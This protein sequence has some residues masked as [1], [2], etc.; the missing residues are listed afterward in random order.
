MAC[1]CRA[2]RITCDP[3]ILHPNFP[4]KQKRVRH[5]NLTLL[6]HLIGIEPMTSPL[7]GER[8]IL[9]SYRCIEKL[10]NISI[11]ISIFFIFSIEISGIKYYN[12]IVMCLQFSWI[13]CKATNFEIG[14]SNP[15]RRAKLSSEF[16][17]FFILL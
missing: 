7:G 13:E 2:G 11:H 6:V 14:G 5:K 12:T 3:Y 4:T 8:S 10:Y 17:S 1:L 15:S 9:L 16:E